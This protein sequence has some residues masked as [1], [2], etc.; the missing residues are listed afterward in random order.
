MREGK[1]LVPK[2]QADSYGMDD[3]SEQFT[4]LWYRHNSP[5]YAD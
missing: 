2:G 5:A 4:R 1:E 3:S